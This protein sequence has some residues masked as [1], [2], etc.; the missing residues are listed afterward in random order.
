MWGIREG[1][2]P[3]NRVCSTPCDQSRK[4]GTGPPRSKGPFFSLLSTKLVTQHK[5]VPVPPALRGDA[6]WQ[7]MPIAR[8]MNTRILHMAAGL[9]QPGRPHRSLAYEALAIGTSFHSSNAQLLSA[10]EL[11]QAP[12]PLS[13]KGQKRP[14]LPL[15]QESESSLFSSQLKCHFFQEV[16]HYPQ[17]KLGPRR[18][19]SWQHVCFL[20]HTYHDGCN[21]LLSIFPALGSSRMAEPVSFLPSRLLNT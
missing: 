6:Q 14:S 2:C 16:T 19:L 18:S 21:D 12:F 8:G 17:S 11:P 13:G 3:S 15:G 1:S 20:L 5:A 7:W 4:Q 9:C 10:P